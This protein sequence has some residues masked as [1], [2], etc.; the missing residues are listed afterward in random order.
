MALETGVE[1]NTLVAWRTGSPQQR[2]SDGERSLILELG[3]HSSAQNPFEAQH[4]DQTFLL[5]ETLWPRNDY[6]G[7]LLGWPTKVSVVLLGSG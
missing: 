6:L 3:F 4:A 7:V 1:E 5:V 2:Q